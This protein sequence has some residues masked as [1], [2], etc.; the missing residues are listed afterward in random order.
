MSKRIPTFRLRR[1]ICWPVLATLPLLAQAQGLPSG[2]RVTAGQASIGAP[3]AGTLQIDQ[4]SARAVLKWND[5]S[6]G[7]GKSVVFKSSANAATL[8]IVTGSN[9]SSLAGSLRADGSVLLMNQ[10]G[11][12]I[13]PTGTVDTRGGFIASTLGIAEDDFMGGRLTFSGKGGRVVNQGRITAGPGGVVGLLGASVANEGVIVAPLGK[14][15]LGSGQAMALDLHG[16][17]FLRVLL[18]SDAVGADG[19]PLVSNTGSI[20]ADG[21]LVMLKAATVR[22]A[23]R[24]A[25][26]MPGEIQARSVSGRDGAIV[27]DGGAGGKVVVAGKL[28]ASAQGD[29]T[30]GGRID[31]TGEA[32]ALQGA[33]VTAT[34]SEQGGL[35]RIGGSFQG[36]KAQDPATPLSQKFAA[37]V[38]APALA[39]AG[40]ASIDANSS[41]DVSATGPAGTG[42]TAIVWSDGN[43]KM[44]GA[45]TAQ[46]AGSAGAVEVSAKSAVQEIALE[47]IQIGKGGTLL[48]DPAN[49]QINGFNSGDPETT[50]LTE[51]GVKSI[52]ETGTDFTAQADQDISWTQG[53]LFFNQPNNPGRVFLTAGRSVH[54]EGTFNT[55]DTDWT[56]TA[57]APAVDESKR[58][59]G[60]AEIN[61]F[62]ATFYNAGTSNGN[63][64]LQIA[65]GAGNTNREVD[66]IRLPAF[67]GNSLTA[68]VDLSNP[69]AG[70]SRITMYRDVDVFEHIT[71]TGHLQ[72]SGSSITLSA[73]TVNWTNEKTGGKFVG[74]EGGTLKFVEG[75]TLTRWGVIRGGNDATRL[76]L[77]NGG[78]HT[79]TYGDTE[80][81]Q[82]SLGDLALRLAAHNVQAAADPLG[83]VLAPGSL[84][85]SGPGSSANAG[86]GYSLGVSA[87]AGSIALKPLEFDADFNIVGGATGSYFIDVAPG[88][89]G[90]TI[91][92]RPLTLSVSSG[93]YTYGSPASVVTLGNIAN[94]D[95]VAPKAVVKTGAGFTGSTVG[96]EAAMQ[97]TGAAGG[98]SADFGLASNTPVAAKSFGVTG[99]TGAKADNYTLDLGGTV[100]ADVTIARKS[101]TYSGAAYSQSYGS[102]ALLSPALDGVVA[103]DDVTGGTQT[104]SVVTTGTAGGS[105]LRPVGVYDIGLSSLAGS[106]A[107]NYELAASGNT[108]SRLTI[109]PKDVTYQ[110][111][112]N[113]NSTYGT[114]ASGMAANLGG[115]ESGDVISPAFTAGGGAIG[116]RLAAGNYTLGV[117]SLDGT[118]SS[119]YQIAAS[120]NTASTL[121]VARKSITY[122]GADAT[123]IYGLTTAAAPE[124]QGIESGDSVG[125]TSQIVASTTYAGAGGSGALVLGDYFSNVTGLTGTDSGNYVIAGS[126]NS[127]RK[128]TVTP[129][130]VTFTLA[131]G[132][133]NTTY[134]TAATLPGVAL[135]NV[136]AGDIITGSLA[137][138]Q[139]STPYAIGDRTAAGS[140]KWGVNALSGDGAG[141]YVVTTVGST[142]ANLVVAKKPI[143]W[144]TAAGSAAYGDALSNA[145]TLN[146]VLSGDV[147]VP[148][149]S[150][151]KTSDS[152]IDLRP[153]V[154]TAYTAAVTAL[155]GDAGG[156]Y[157]LQGSGNSAGSV[158]I[159]PRPLTYSV[160]N[161]NSTYGTLAT[162]GA[163]TLSNVAYGETLAPTIGVFDGSTPVTLAAKT[164][165]GSY[166]ERVTALNNANYAIAGSGNTDG[167]LNIAKKPLAFA[168]P[169]G[170]SVYGSAHVYTTSG[171]ASLAGVLGGDDVTAGGIA[172][173]GSFGERTDAGAYAGALR[174]GSL[175]GASASNYQLTDAGSTFGTL[176]VAPKALNYSIILEYNGLQVTSP[177]TYGSM[178]GSAGFEAN[179]GF[180]HGARAATLTGVASWDAG[181]VFLDIANPGLT[182]STGGFYNVG[183]YTYTGTG[184]RTDGTG[185][186]K[187]SN[188]VVASSGNTDYTLQINPRP[189]NVI[190]SAQ[191]NGSLA[192]SAVYGTANEVTPNAQYS[193]LGA[194]NVTASAAFQTSGG[195]LTS[196]PAKLAVGN[197]PVVIDGALGGSDASNY[198]AN[199]V[200]NSFSSLTVSPKPIT[201]DVANT[202]STYGTLGTAGGVSL[203]GV[204]AGDTVA[205]SGVTVSRAGSPVTLAANSS[206]GGYT[207]SPSGLT[208]AEAG[209][210]SLVAN[211]GFQF[212][213]ETNSFSQSRDGVHT[214]NTAP[215]G[216]VLPVGGYSQTYGTVLAMPTLSGILFGDTVNVGALAIPTEAFRHTGA[217]PDTKNLATS[218]LLDAQPYLLSASLSGAGAGNYHLTPYN[219]NFEI[220]KK[221]LTLTGSF[222]DRS[223]TYGTYIGG[224]TP[225]LSGVVGGQ[226]VRLVML[227]FA[228]APGSSFSNS[229]AYNERTGAGIYTD[230]AALDGTQ[231]WNYTLPDAQRQLTINK[232]ALTFTPAT[233]PNATY[234]TLN[235]SFG[236]LSGML[237]NDD[238]GVTA[239]VSGQLTSAP[240]VRDGTNYNYAPKLNAGSY[241]YTLNQTGLTGAAAGNYSLAPSSSSGV[242]TVAPKPILWSVGNATGQYGNFKACESGQ[243]CYPWTPGIAL[244]DTALYGVLAGDTVTGTRAVLD[245][246]GVF[247]TID[248]RTPVGRYFQVVTG[249]TGA[250]AGNYTIAPSGNLPGILDIV[251]VWL[252]YTTSSAVF[253]P[254]AG[255]VGTPGV[256]TIRSGGTGNV[257]NG[258]QVV[259]VVNAVDP[260]G[261]TV[262]NLDNLV[263]GRYSFP[264]RALTGEDAGNYRIM[265]ANA[266]FASG[267][268]SNVD[269]GTLDVFASSTLGLGYAST[270]AVIPKPAPAPV[271][272]TQI[273]APPTDGSSYARTG[274][275]SDF[276]RQYDATGAGLN[277]SINGSSNIVTGAAGAA[278]RTDGVAVGDG[279][280]T[281]QASAGINALASLGVTGVKLIGNAS[282][283]VDVQIT[284]GPGYVM[285]GLQGDAEGAAKFGPTG[286]SL[287]AEARAGA[288]ASGGAS[289][290]LGVVGSG[291]ADAQAG[292]FVYARSLTG[293]SWTDLS[294]Q[295][296]FDQSV[297]A[298]GSVGGHGGISGSHG[299]LDAGATLYSPGVLGAKFDFSGGFSGSSLTVGLD[300]GLM[301]GIGGLDLSVNFTVD[302]D[303]TFR[304]LGGLPEMQAAAQFLG[305]TGTGPSGPTRFAPTLL[306]R[307]DALKSD[308]V[309]RF[310]YLT[311]NPDWRG[312][313]PRGSGSTKEL[314][315]LYAANEKFYN[316]YQALLTKTANVL[317][318]H[319]DTQQKFLGLLSTDPAAAIAMAHSG[320]INN[321][322]NRQGDLNWE[323][324]ALGVRMEVKDGKV[325]YVTK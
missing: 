277:L 254:G 16:D 59:A 312:Y 318:S 39:N 139:G 280:L 157:A 124:L 190:L 205:A 11:I 134:G 216:L 209:N 2:G 143:T 270:Q 228:G 291:A 103:G 155:G 12:A 127:F 36:G 152:S 210:Y 38:D 90:L 163:A 197:Y 246:N 324:K 133:S 68:T 109:T 121:F 184:V 110:M 32:V 222:V 118:G 33:T 243:N 320:E 310:K 191:R 308:P 13:T 304:T 172:L 211:G 290:S 112:G 294:V 7:Q 169:D 171:S 244:G 215:L 195:N 266:Q 62:G 305:M 80:A 240:L 22:Q 283:H 199:P 186:A 153:S 238:V 162:V 5:F 96:S 178:V 89:V 73:G 272:P 4:A 3:N 8:N 247:G 128:T 180:G 115:I 29:A 229:I 122:G 284:V 66:G 175:S 233:S 53:F 74:G 6:I 187:A 250:S 286:A 231:R 156:N 137:A 85:V 260:K 285:A 201:Y 242:F 261:V 325:S 245:S 306:E 94:G 28:D 151:I 24:D 65:S 297:G 132:S 279:T 131:G 300:L 257:I 226:D 174:V 95:A 76:E 42:G 84:S 14:V 20:Q 142:D 323:A 262:A 154:G 114:A 193:P 104:V 183:T 208:G 40:T 271:P 27:L 214:I 256:P 264:V 75:G 17:G 221:A 129:R 302:L 269:V 105:G 106:T 164:N 237:F 170:N 322:V 150:A 166:A 173:N 51:A 282:T 50:Y 79:R 130:A 60:L 18:P 259:P 188:Y 145:T 276:G 219:Q 119:N 212:Q 144:T 204:L 46:G 120:G 117:G 281:G 236:S 126:G 72:H 295:T 21:G 135:G 149:L 19:Q 189:L 113:V 26:Y 99:L 101:I 299:N 234:G 274:D 44:A 206:A 165:A 61:M 220:A 108:P 98:S 9:A 141:N 317:K 251:P 87:N 241:S 207:V 63:L 179:N 31:V 167:T 198:V 136:V 232:K 70:N 158:T 287:T 35:V 161:A 97:L 58:G 168:A 55:H 123:Q 293:A 49:I 309:A 67:S 146:S 56:I 289:G 225:A 107:P 301:I 203:T 34:G 78:T 298:G 258:D 45:I 248:G 37:A 125:V 321:L 182:R 48:L 54:V 116:A 138:F 194:D 275:T 224:Q 25:V 86:T 263:P 278:T 252:S 159:T 82:A 311:E 93:N 223:T 268:F 185:L 296:K 77:G 1:T 176:T 69:A 202:S 81:D 227:T 235:T 177:V 91:A 52:L 313:D 303:K 314:T 100:S 23:V 200:T 218:P 160:A 267:A 10:N 71:L 192:S 265:P 292:V 273:V 140:Y 253:L 15:A 255:I 288:Y 319:A 83:Q 47:R 239:N 30:K 307:A 217:S 316:D 64:K 88:T 147:V 249:L 148:T 41:I 230:Y 213:A 102:A 315:A 92:K 111:A 196:L 43:T 181:R 57:N